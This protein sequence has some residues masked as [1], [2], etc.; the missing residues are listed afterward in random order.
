VLGQLNG[1]TVLGDQ[2]CSN[3]YYYTKLGNILLGTEVCYNSNQN[4]W[5]FCLRGKV[6]Y[7]GTGHVIN[8]KLLK[9]FRLNFEFEICDL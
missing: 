7:N 6:H 3:T 4:I 9:T 2:I 8:A 5:H 1:S